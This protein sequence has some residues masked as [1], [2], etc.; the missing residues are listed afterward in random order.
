MM[1]KKLESLKY[2]KSKLVELVKIKKKKIHLKLDLFEQNL[3]EL[4]LQL[5]FHRRRK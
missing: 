5:F 1:K 2:E 4:S 3:S